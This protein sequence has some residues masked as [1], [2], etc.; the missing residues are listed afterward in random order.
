MRRLQDHGAVKIRP[1]RTISRKLR[2]RRSNSI[3]TGWWA[4]STAKGA[5]RSRC[6]AISMCVRRPAAPSRL[7]RRPTP[8]SSRCARRTHRV[9]RFRPASA[10]GTP[11]QRVDLRGRLARR[12]R[13]SGAALLRALSTAGEGSRLPTLRRHRAVDAPEGASG[14]RQLRAAR[15]DR[16]FD[17]RGTGSNDRGRS[18]KSLQDPQRLHA[19]HHGATSAPTGEDTVRPSWRHEESGQK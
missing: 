2:G 19:R 10:Q 13:G 17:E 3:R 8:G 5:S 7:P 18:T 16:L 15:P 4:S 1:V 6:T 12:A 14:T 9:L 11:E